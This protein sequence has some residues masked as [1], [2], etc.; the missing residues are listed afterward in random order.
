M[1]V[2]DQQCPNCDK[3]FERICS[4]NED[5]VPCPDCGTQ[6][7]RIIS[8]RGCFTANE[9]AAWIRSVLE[10]VDKD[11]KGVA[12]QRFLKNPTRTNYKK[13]MKDTGLRHLEPGEKPTKPASFDL[14]RHTDKVMELRNK[15]TRIEI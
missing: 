2:Y 13:W 15:R 6:A 11:D 12:T 4:V 3:I 5:K 14:K 8:A 9:D 7:H 10:V 1:P